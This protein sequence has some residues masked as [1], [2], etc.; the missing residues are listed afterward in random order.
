MTKDLSTPL[1][2]TPEGRKQ[3]WDY[4]IRNKEADVDLDTP[5]NFFL[6]LCL[7]HYSASV[8]QVFQ[9]LYVLFKL[10]QK[11]GGY[12]VEFGAMDGV[13]ISNT[14]RLE[15]S[16]GWRGILAEPN[17]V[18]HDALKGNR[19]AVIDRRCVWRETGTML[20]FDMGAQPEL[21]SIS[22]FSSAVPANR[23]T[24]ESVSLRD[25]LRE[26]NA[27][28]VVD[29]LSVDTEGS[30]LEIL[31]AFD[32]SYRFRVITIEHNY[33][34]AARDALHVLLGSRGYVREFEIFSRW[35]DWYFHP[36]LMP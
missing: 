22:G 6:G 36:E 18:F 25:L 17:P 26:H 21:S 23:T 34:R 10:R 15:Q 5:E 19:K 28:P 32:F 33:K 24:V 4:L 16:F 35:D 29:Y 14:Y 7:A 12:F 2:D 1:L 20:E 9:D 31:Q 3:L 27:P 13:N 30:E 8:S 11:R